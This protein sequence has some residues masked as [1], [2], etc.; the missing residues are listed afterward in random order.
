MFFDLT[1]RV[2][3][4]NVLMW[5]KEIKTNAEE[6]AVIV[7]VGNKKDLTLENLASRQ[8][9]ESEAKEL[10]AKHGL[11]YCETSAKTGD[12]VKETFDLLVESKP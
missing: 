3:Y 9:K 12:N 5:L 10:A 6:G 7:L 1:D 4:E 11:Y 2:S 8:V